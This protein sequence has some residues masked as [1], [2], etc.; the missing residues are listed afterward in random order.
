VSV[1]Q[2]KHQ[3]VRDLIRSALNR[4]EGE[5]TRPSQTALRR[6]VSDSYYAVFHAVCYL[7]ADGLVGWSTPWESFEPIYR[8]LDHQEAKKR[9]SA[10]EISVLGPEVRRIGEILRDLIKDRHT[11]DYDPRPF[12]ANKAEILAKI[13]QAQEAV[14][15][16]EALPKATY[17]KLAVLL[18]ARSRRS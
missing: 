11:A 15:L 13:A 10:P 12:K 5:T 17:R 3:I 14:D 9:F 8:S 2:I 7:V 6:A 18:I 16:I 4:V 1:R